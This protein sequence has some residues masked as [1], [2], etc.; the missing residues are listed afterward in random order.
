MK[1]TPNLTA[2]FPPLAE[3]Q[4]RQT[5]EGQAHF[6]GSGPFGATCGECAHLGYYRQVRNG[7]G[8]TV[9]TPFT[10]GCS[11]FYQLTG[12]HGP[13]V[14]GHAESCRHFERR[15]GGEK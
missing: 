12:K 3:Q 13:V 4:I 10:G 9:A 5:Y 6:A 7:R 15:E 2:G 11:K 1:I 14:P 8:E